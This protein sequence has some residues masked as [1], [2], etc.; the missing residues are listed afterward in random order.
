M[1]FS[2]EPTAI[3]FALVAVTACGGSI[4]P[5]PGESAD[6]SSTGD[7]SSA[8]DAGTNAA[9][10]AAALDANTP[11]TSAPPPDPSP[12]P[13]QCVLP[14]GRLC[15]GT[16]KCDDGCNTCACVAGGGYS[17]TDIACP[18]PKPTPACTASDVTPSCRPLPAGDLQ[19]SGGTYFCAASVLAACGA[20][21]CPS[22]QCALSHANNDGS[23]WCC[24]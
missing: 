2:C 8:T 22:T 10:D 3:L 23:F 11:C 18:P 5:S 7:S 1:R 4:A 13:G 15:N 17:T 14:S 24:P 12:A 19:C 21:S 9:P 20:S 6:A 16:C